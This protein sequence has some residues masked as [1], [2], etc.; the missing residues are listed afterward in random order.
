MSPKDEIAEL[1]AEVSEMDAL[2]ERLDRQEREIAEVKTAN[3]SLRSKI[4]ELEMQLPKPP[5]QSQAE[6]RAAQIARAADG[7]RA[8][9]KQL[10]ISK[11]CSMS[12]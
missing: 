3:S 9:R 7:R 11:L 6:E 10:A 2:C 1:R 12:R 5:A 8:A 4:A